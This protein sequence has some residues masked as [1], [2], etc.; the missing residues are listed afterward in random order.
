[1]TTASTSLPMRSNTTAASSRSPAQPSRQPSLSSFPSSNKRSVSASTTT[2]T[3]TTHNSNLLHQPQP[4]SP[5]YPGSA[6]SYHSSFSSTHNG[7]ETRGSASGTHP[8]SNTPSIAA[9]ASPP[10]KPKMIKSQ[11]PSNSKEKHVEYILVASFDIDRGSVMEHQYPGPVGGDEHMLA[12]LML[13]DQAHVRAQDWT[14]F[15]LHKDAAAEEDERSLRRRRRRR[16]KARQTVGG[17]GA[18]G[19]GLGLEEG[20][21]AGE[22]DSAEA[23]DES[24]DDLLDEDEEETDSDEELDRMADGPPLVYVLN[25]VNTKHDT[26]TRRGAICKAMAV[27][28]RHSFLHIYKPLLLIALEKYFADPTI[29]TLASLYNA[30][31]GMDLSLLPRLSPYEKFLLQGTDAKDLFIEKFETI[32]AQHMVASGSAG[33][34]EDTSPT[35]PNQ[36]QQHQQ[37]RSRYGLPR[38][39]HEFESVVN[40]MNIPVPIKIPTALAVETVGDFSLVNLIKIFTTPHSTSPQPFNPLHPHLTTGGPTTHPIIVLVNALL[41]QKRIIILGHNLPSSDVADAV[42]AACALASGGM[43]RGFTRHAFPYTDLTKI[44]DLLKVP[45]FIA[46]VTNPAFS[47]HEEWWDLLCD[48]STGRMRVSKKIEQPPLEEGVAFF[49]QGGP[50]ALAK[51][52]TASGSAAAGLMAAA[53]A[54]LGGNN[55]STTTLPISGHAAGDATGDAAFMSQVLAA[56]NERHGEN[57]IRSKFRLWVLKF[58]RLAAAFE[59]CVYGASALHVTIPSAA[60]TTSPK[61]PF[62]GEELPYTAFATSPLSPSGVPLPSTPALVS[63]T[64]QGHGYV[65]PTPQSRNL[66]LAA[67][68]TRIEGWRNTRSYYNLIQDLAGFYNHVP[69]K[70][71]DLQHLHDKLAKLRLP[72][73][74]AGEIYLAICSNIYAEQE[75][76][77]LLSVIINGSFDNRGGFGAAGHGNNSN[78][79]SSGSNGSSGTNGGQQGLFYISM[80]LFHS[81]LEVREAVA[82]LLLRVQRN[83][84]GRHFWAGLGRFAKMAWGR[85]MKG[86]EE[87]MGKEGMDMT[88]MVPF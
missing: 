82:L 39:T 17:A 65:W 12:E 16:R 44:D 64:T 88:G 47:H 38:D 11:Y 69:V 24:D 61:S 46:G 58:T 42:L 21:V 51:D 83:D 3:A 85:V 86:R 5:T 22:E 28:T 84:A 30:V 71:L 4:F 13:P 34:L 50:G 80:G 70:N 41:T 23:E 37:P 63:E 55:S 43:L 6:H 67:N 77:Q 8:S 29:D 27:C 57:A 78:N 2:T 31:N 32:I 36:H 49:Q 52:G 54:S 10:R 48:L 1:M 18:E 7:G 73:P 79:A 72:P 33:Q 45:G 14:I 62:T 56:I 60:A 40:Y 25:L 59:E 74:V 20:S 68:A 19:G 35:S 76:C 26:T 15:F 9:I 81:K 75:I 87:R 66:E 53:G